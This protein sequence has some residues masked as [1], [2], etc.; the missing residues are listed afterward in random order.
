[1][2]P[3]SV[4][5]FPPQNDC[6]QE[7]T[8]VAEKPASIEFASVGKD[9]FGLRGRRFPGPRRPLEKGAPED[10]HVPPTNV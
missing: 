10:F 5:E 3:R 1:M 2:N 7:K 4:K 8:P 6:R 9:H